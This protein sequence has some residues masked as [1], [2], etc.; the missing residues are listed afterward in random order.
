MSN[1]V[2]KV[3]KHG[4]EYVKYVLVP[5]KDSSCEKCL[6]FTSLADCADH[7]D[8]CYQE[9]VIWKEATEDEYALAKLRGIAS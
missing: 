9:A 6:F 8:L 2:R 7:S 5:R 3:M 1:D 4:N